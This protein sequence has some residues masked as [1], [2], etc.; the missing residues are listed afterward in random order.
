[1][2]LTTNGLKAI[3]TVLRSV[4]VRADNLFVVATSEREYEL[5]VSSSA[6]NGGLFSVNFESGHQERLLQNGSDD[7]QR[8][9]GVCKRAVGV[10][11][12]VDRGNKKFKVFNRELGEVRVLAGSGSSGAKD[13][14]ETSAS[15]SQPSAVWCEQGSSTVCVTDTSKGR[16]R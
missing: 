1:M 3:A 9:H 6:D 2:S 8:I 13:G 16:L 7:L 11:I 4:D 15:F 12:M 5:Y 10:L 14:S